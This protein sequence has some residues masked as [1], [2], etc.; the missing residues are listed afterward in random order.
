MDYQAFGFKTYIL[1]RE[2][3]PYDEMADP[4]L[5]GN[6]G[7]SSQPSSKSVS[8]WYVIL[9]IKTSLYEAKKSTL[10]KKDHKKPSVK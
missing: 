2:Y 7:A 10:N 6:I 9:I 4:E 3:C 5:K 8:S 1:I